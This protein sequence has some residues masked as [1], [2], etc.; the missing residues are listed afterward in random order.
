MTRCEV[1]EAR[2]SPAQRELTRDRRYVDKLERNYRE[3]QR[4]FDMATTEL[5]AGLRA[6]EQRYGCERDAV[7]EAIR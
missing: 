1:H 5:E 6:F 2:V 7:C 4:R 3:C